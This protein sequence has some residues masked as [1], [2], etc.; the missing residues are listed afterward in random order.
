MPRIPSQAEWE[1]REQVR[2]ALIA[3]LR[4][5]VDAVRALHREVERRPT[6]KWWPVRLLMPFGD[7]TVCEHCTYNLLGGD[8]DNEHQPFAFVLYPCPTIRRLDG[9]PAPIRSRDL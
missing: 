4:G 5:K 9:Q 6:G 7:R 3:Q 1:T 8:A 2:D